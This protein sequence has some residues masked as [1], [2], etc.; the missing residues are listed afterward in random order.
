MD[1]DYGDSYRVEDMWVVI[2]VIV[3]GYEWIVIIVL[4]IG[5]G[6]NKKEFVLGVWKL[7]LNVVGV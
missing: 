6:V 7:L 5:L 1:S 3:I 2:I 4:V